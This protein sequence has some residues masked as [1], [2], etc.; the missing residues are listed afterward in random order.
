MKCNFCKKEVTFNLKVEGDVGADA[1]WCDECYCNLD[2]YDMP[3][4]NSLKK[5]LTTWTQQYGEWMDWSKDMLCSN[6]VQM[7]EEHNKIGESLTV[8]VRNELGDEY[9][10]RFS[11]SSSTRMYAN[12]DS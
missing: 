3:I 1:I 11:P 5:Q 6:G 12:R 8:K 4:S 7:E 2:I 9:K 10:V